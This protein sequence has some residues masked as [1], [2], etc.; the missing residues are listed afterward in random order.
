MYPARLRLA[1]GAALG[2]TL[3]A[4]SALTLSASGAGSPTTATCPPAATVA[5]A[6]GPGAKVGHAVAAHSAYGTTCTYAGAMLPTRISFQFDTMTTFLAGERAASA[7]GT[8]VIHHLGQAAWGAK[9][10][11]GVYVYRDGETIK[12]VAPLVSNV[13]LVA[14]ARTLI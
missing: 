7:Y 13:R 4:S 3:L 5:K 10:G 1:G 12:I 8:V 11:G 2:I 14:L 6:F 9:A